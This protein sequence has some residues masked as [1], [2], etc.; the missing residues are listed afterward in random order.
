MEFDQCE[1]RHCSLLFDYCRPVGFIKFKKF[2]NEE[3]S[4]IKLSIGQAYRSWH[5]EFLN[6]VP[7]T[8]NIVYVIKI[9]LLSIFSNLI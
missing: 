6:M 9:G 2:T 3:N 7:M 5:D 4:E 1:I 8:R